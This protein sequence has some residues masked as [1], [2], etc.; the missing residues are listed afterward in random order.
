MLTKAWYLGRTAVFASLAALALGSLTTSADAGPRHWHHG[1]GAA[2]AAGFAAALLLGGALI[3]Y[4]PWPT[5]LSFW[6]LAMLLALLFVALQLVK[7]FVRI[8][9]VHALGV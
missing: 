4:A 5:R 6:V 2:A 8:G 7:Q 9:T 1:G 3:A